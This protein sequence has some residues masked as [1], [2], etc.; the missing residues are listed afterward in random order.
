MFII[1]EIRKIVQ[2]PVRTAKEPALVKWRED[3]AGLN[4]I[5]SDILE[6]L[7]PFISDIQALSLART[8]TV[9]FK[10]GYRITSLYSIMNNV[11]YTI[12]FCFVPVVRPFLGDGST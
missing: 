4:I 3:W 9:T 8:C 6:L 12:L 2:D 1:T 7:K 5:M 10:R 11:D